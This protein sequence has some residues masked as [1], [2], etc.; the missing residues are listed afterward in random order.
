MMKVNEHNIDRIVR[1]VVA[2]ALIFWAMFQWPV[3]LAMPWAL[4]AYLVGA[5]FIVNSVIG[6]CP[7]YGLLRIST[8]GKQK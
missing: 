4:I 5:V 2:V 8:A 1:F 3:E 6:F 7:L